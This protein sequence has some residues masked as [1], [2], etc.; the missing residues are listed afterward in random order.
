MELLDNIDMGLPIRDYKDNI[1]EDFR[2][3]SVNLA[4]VLR[5]NITKQ[6]IK[7][8]LQTKEVYQI[9]KTPIERNSFNWTI[10]ENKCRKWQWDSVY[11]GNYLKKRLGWDAT[12][13]TKRQNTDTKESLKPQ[14]IPNSHGSVMRGER[15]YMWYTYIL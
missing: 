13:T 10:L 14:V 4:R 11:L 5:Y 12:K 9:T 6:I 3:I 1:I 8:Y 7:N 2:L 15:V